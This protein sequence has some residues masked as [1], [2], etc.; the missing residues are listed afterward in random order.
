MI[1]VTFIATDCFVNIVKFENGEFKLGFLKERDF[2]DRQSE[3][4]V[5]V[6]IFDKTSMRLGKIHL[7]SRSKKRNRE[8]LAKICFTYRL[9]FLEKS[10]QF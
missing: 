2:N 3:A 10:F 4:K 8:T 7:S 9:S 1:S 6:I 5:E